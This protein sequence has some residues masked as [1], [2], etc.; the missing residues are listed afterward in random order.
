M[1]LKDIYKFSSKFERLSS[2]N[3]AKNSD[4]VLREI[5][6]AKSYDD[7]IA[8]AEKNYEKLGEGSSRTV[9]KVSNDLVL[10]V[11][12][13][14]KG[15]AQNLVEMDPNTHKSFINQVIAAD[16]KGKWIL[17]RFTENL[18]EKDFKDIVGFDF[19]H[20]MDALLYKFNNESDDWKKPKD[21][22]EIEKSELFQELA[23]FVLENDSQIGDLAKIS[24]WGKSGNTV[25]LRDV[26]LSR[27]VYKKYYEDK[28]SS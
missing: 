14:P 10:K 7:R 13:D 11:A 8:I 16:A 15:I 18:T 20:F 21:Y 17:I 22:E 4:P 24:S 26:G 9:F 23:E 27:D 12:H 3:L 2:I 6:D 1:N 25:V 19:N 28:S 5:S